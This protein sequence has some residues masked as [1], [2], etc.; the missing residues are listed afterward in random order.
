MKDLSALCTIDLSQFENFIV[1]VGNFARANS[2]LSPNR[3]K[4]KGSGIKSS[5]DDKER[6]GRI[7]S[8]I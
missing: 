8:I 3:K 4:K 2:F 5:T 1:G 6:Y 7:Y